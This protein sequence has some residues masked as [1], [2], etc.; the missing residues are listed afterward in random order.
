MTSQ[1]FIMN[2]LPMASPPFIEADTYITLNII[3]CHVFLVIS[4][5]VLSLQS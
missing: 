4:F 1:R 5:D 3:G 2:A